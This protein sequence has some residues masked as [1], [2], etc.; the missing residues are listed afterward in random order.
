MGW[1]SLTFE[2]STMTLRDDFFFF[3]R[4]PKRAEFSDRMERDDAMVGWTVEASR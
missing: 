4:D 1:R 3:L 2:T